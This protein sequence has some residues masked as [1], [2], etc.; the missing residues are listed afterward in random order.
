MT[1]IEAEQLVLMISKSSLDSLLSGPFSKQTIP[2]K[3]NYPAQL[4]TQ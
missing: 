2:E 4:A 1:Q 3:V